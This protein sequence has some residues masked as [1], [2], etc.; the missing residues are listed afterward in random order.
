MSAPIDIAAVRVEMERKRRVREEER[1][2]LAAEE[3]ARMEAE[4]KELGRLEEERKKREEEVKVEEARRVEEAERV[5][6][7]KREREAAEVTV[8]RPRPVVVVPRHSP[9]KP[10]PG[11]FR[12]CFFCWFH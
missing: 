4:L 5:E 12:G 10:A 9:V 7:E 3:D 11:E 2:R 1:A 6:R 8:H